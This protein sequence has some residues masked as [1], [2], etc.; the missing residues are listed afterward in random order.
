MS[1]SPA[2]GVV[3][4]SN[5]QEANCICGWM[6]VSRCVSILA[7]FFHLWRN[8]F[9]L[10]SHLVKGQDLV[11][12][13]VKY[14]L[15]YHLRAAHPAAR[16]CGA[17]LQT[18]VSNVSVENVFVMCVPVPF[19]LTYLC[20]CVRGFISSNNLEHQK[21]PFLSFLKSAVEGASGLRKLSDC[22]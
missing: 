9:A 22:S 8:C 18:F 5:R 4:S 12:S 3:T 17:A 20:L 7:G 14:L 16:D 10:Q 13:F 6:H 19:L 21:E 1:M 2:C 11:N 15:V